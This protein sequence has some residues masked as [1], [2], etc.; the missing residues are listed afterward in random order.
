MKKLIKVIIVILTISQISCKAKQP[1]LDI[2]TIVS[3]IGEVHNTEF[4]VEESVYD[5][6]TYF[7]VI[8]DYQ[9]NIFEKYYSN[10]ITDNDDWY[11]SKDMDYLYKQIKANKTFQYNF[12]NKITTSFIHNLYVTNYFVF[13]VGDYQDIR[14]EHFIL[15][16]YTDK[17][18]ILQIL[19]NDVEKYLEELS[20]HDYII[21]T[22]DCLSWN[23][24]EPSINTLINDLLSNKLSNTYIEQFYKFSEELLKQVR[25]FLES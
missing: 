23:A 12:G 17:A 1:E 22:E 25:F 24:S 7:T 18:I 2:E 16:F 14:I 9:I 19:D 21:N 3:K 20:L 6:K 13:A 4:M 5:K 15:L 11:N 8:N 10:K